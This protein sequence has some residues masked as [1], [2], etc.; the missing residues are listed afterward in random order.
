M[1]IERKKSEREEFYAEAELTEAKALELWYDDSETADQIFEAQALSEG[2]LQAL[3]KYRPLANNPRLLKQLTSNTT[4]V[5]GFN[6]LQ[7]LARVLAQVDNSQRVSGSTLDLKS[8][9]AGTADH[10][11]PHF[12]HKCLHIGPHNSAS[13]DT[14]L[15]LRIFD[16]L[17]QGS[18]ARFN[19]EPDLS[20][21]KTSEFQ[22]VYPSGFTMHVECK[23]PEVEDLILGNWLDVSADLEA[24]KEPEAPDPQ[25]YSQKILECIENAISKF[26]HQDGPFLPV[27][28]GAAFMPHSHC[29]W[30][31]DLKLP[32]NC[33]GILIAR[34]KLEFVPNGA[35]EEAFL[36]EMGPG[37]E[38]DPTVIWD[39]SWP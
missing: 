30:L 28:T 36:K 32:D 33:V 9:L 11:R 24:E 13:Y 8:K 16:F 19:W 35:Y 5:D 15:E 21:G 6:S 18:N 3:Q 22:A 37:A 29:S 10:V 1:T 2:E 12:G 7:R 4:K 38:N 31:K 23:N 34:D 14:L 26:S 25:K 27:V 39:H 17:Y 20:T